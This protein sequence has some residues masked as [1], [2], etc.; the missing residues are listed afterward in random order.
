LLEQR[1]NNVVPQKQQTQQ[2]PQAQPQ[3]EL[4]QQDQAALNWANANSN[5]PRAKRIKDKL[6]VQ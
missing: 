2:A 5:D 1:F 4:S 6:G 3:K